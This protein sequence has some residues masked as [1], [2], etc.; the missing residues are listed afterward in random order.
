M[1]T[2]RS[3]VMTQKSVPY[4]SLPCTKLC[5]CVYICI[6]IYMC[7]LF[8]LM[9]APSWQIFYSYPLKCALVSL[10]VC[11]FS[12]FFRSPTCCALRSGDSCFAKCSRCTAFSEA[13]NTQTLE[14][15]RAEVACTPSEV[16]APSVRL[17]ATLECCCQRC[18]VS[19]GHIYTYIYSYVL[20]NAWTETHAHTRTHQHVHICIY[21]I[22]VYTY[23]YNIVHT[24]M[25]RKEAEFL[26]FVSRLHTLRFTHIEG[27]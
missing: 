26:L 19:W 7:P 1:I 3:L 23:R 9:R 20:T 13:V 21:N 24:M 25:T 4:C 15:E 2:V 8:H 5:V 10:K 17:P 22:Y 6:Y 12:T 14:S 18:S 16:S 27:K 11:L